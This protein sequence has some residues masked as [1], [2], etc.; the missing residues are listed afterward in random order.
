M[1]LYTY[2]RS[3]ASFR[4]RIA[5]KLKG[6]AWEPAFVHLPRGE[7][8][9]AG[10][11]EKN[12][13]GLVPAL[14]DGDA[15]LTQSLA[16]IE[17]LDETHPEPP[18]LPSAPVDRARVRAMAMVVACD[19]HPLNNLQV[20]RYLK[21]TLGQE[22]EEIDRWY[23]HWVSRGFEGLE[24]LV[25]HHGSETFCFGDRLSLADICL[26]PQMWNARRF[27]T[28][29]SPFP[30]LVRIDAHLSRLPAFAEAAPDAQ[31]DAF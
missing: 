28:D 29:L 9:E 8:K 7:Q 15:V 17:Y 21:D 10:Y 4:V 11:R 22:Q 23:R 14:E 31:P 12:P 26:V 20:L 30:N 27:R 6:I 1:K 2:F 16:I 13:Q 25:R 24:A 18:F 19:I 5:L 3:S